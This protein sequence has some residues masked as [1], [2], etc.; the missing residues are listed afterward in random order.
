MKFD[1]G[2]EPKAN[3]VASCDLEKGNMESTLNTC[4]YVLSRTFYTQGQAHAMMEPHTC[5]AYKDFQQRLVIASSTQVP[6]HVRRIVGKALEIPVHQ[7]KV[8]NAYRWWFWW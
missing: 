3:I 6:F 7:I 1:L 4:D 8:I 2:Y 5:F